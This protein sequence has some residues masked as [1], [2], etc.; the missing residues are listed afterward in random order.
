M[1]LSSANLQICIT[2]QSSL[3]F[4]AFGNI[5]VGKFLF[6]H[7][8]SKLC[9]DHC[10]QKCFI[11]FLRPVCFQN[12]RTDFDFKMLRR[13]FYFLNTINSDNYFLLKSTS[14]L[15]L[16]SFYQLQD[17]CRTKPIRALIISVCGSTTLSQRSGIPTTC[18]SARGRIYRWK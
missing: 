3:D 1:L 6:M 13:P 10:F 18:T 5:L 2:K 7:Q 9:N 4:C 14:F 17:G 8:N 16:F 11:R 12:S 15:L